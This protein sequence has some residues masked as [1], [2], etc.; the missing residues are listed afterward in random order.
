MQEYFKNVNEKLDQGWKMTTVSCGEG[1]C[2]T[3]LLANITEQK[4]FCPKCKSTKDAELKVESAP[5]PD[6]YAD[7]EEDEDKEDNY[8]NLASKLMSKSTTVQ[9]PKQEE[10]KYDNSTKKLSEYLLMGYTMLEDCCQ[11]CCLPYVRDRR[12]KTFCPGCEKEKNK[13]EENNKKKKEAPKVT[14]ISAP[15]IN[16]VPTQNP[17]PEPAQSIEKP[18]QKPQ[19]PPQTP[20]P[21]SQP[22]LPTQSLPYPFQQPLPNQ[23]QP[24]QNLQPNQ[25][26]P[27]QPLQNQNPLQPLQTFPSPYSLTSLHPLA[28]S[29]RESFLKSLSLQVE[30]IE[31][32]SLSRAQKTQQIY[33]LLKQYGRD[34]L[35]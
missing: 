6:P 25:N 31:A 27:N 10:E 17:P 34:V 28:H 1:P 30:E 11:E 12:G 19:T 8:D 23:S 4:T 2:T 15:K 33:G 3:S 9:T 5:A 20:L 14:N 18:P 21:A 24:L 22:P 26:L 7:F 13:P 35:G 29:L 16:P 32:S